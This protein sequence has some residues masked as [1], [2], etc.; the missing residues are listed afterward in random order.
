MVS[1][2][3]CPYH[4]SNRVFT[5]CATASGELISR[6]HHRCQR[7]NRHRRLRV[8]IASVRR[9]CVTAAGLYSAVRVRH[10]ALTTSFTSL[11]TVTG[12][13]SIVAVPP[14]SP[15]PRERFPFIVTLP[16]SVMVGD[17]SWFLLLLS[18][19]ARR[20]F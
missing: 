3:H 10:Q 8:C 16:F 1:R 19:S 4:N 17:G 7:Y 6:C 9:S 15:I 13:N 20:G 12:L 5:A 14:L 2:N 18:P 11:V